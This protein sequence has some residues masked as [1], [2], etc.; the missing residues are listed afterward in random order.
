MNIQQIEYIIAVSK[1][2][3]FQ[4]A[5]D[6]CNIT[7]STLSTMIGKFEDEIG[8]KIFDRKT[9]PVTITKEGSEILIQLKKIIQEVGNL[10]EITQNLKGEL[11]GDLNIAVIP[12]IAPYL[13]PL[14][15]NDF[16]KKYPAIKFS[17]SELTT[18][19][20]FENIKNR[21]IDI[22]IVSLPLEDNNLIEIPLYDEHF[23]VYN[24]KPSPKKSVSLEEL[25]MDKIWLLEEGHCMRNQI[26]SICNSKRLKNG[27]HNNLEYKS[28]TI[29]TL[30]KFVNLN[31]GLTLLPYLS[32]LDFNE[33]EQEK[34]TKI[35]GP[36]LVR[37]I[38]LVVHPH[39]IKKQILDSL[40][41]EIL[42]KLPKNLKKNRDEKIIFSPL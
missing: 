34:I 25:D 9:K 22:A 2:F 8:I 14:F 5:A 12:T 10:K 11:S 31:K 32:T 36:K 26:V 17:I 40:K 16:I 33:L 4:Q 18:S 24:H 23:L 21:E 38:G 15:I 35:E 30:L 7:Q 28:G 42:L 19:K 29:N 37:S 39:F 3:N 41:N 1:Y 20:I 27:V 6:S 13:L